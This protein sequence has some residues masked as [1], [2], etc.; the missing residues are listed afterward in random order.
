M[1]QPRMSTTVRRRHALRCGPGCA[2]I[3]CVKAASDQI[4]RVIAIDS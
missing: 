2:L 4:T 1:A 3:A